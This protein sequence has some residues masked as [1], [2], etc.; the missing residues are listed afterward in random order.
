MI[1]SRQ[2]WIWGIQNI[3]DRENSKCKDSEARMNLTH[4]GPE[5][6]P[7][8]LQGL[9]V[10]GGADGPR[11]AILNSVGQKWVA[12]FWASSLELGRAKFYAH[13]PQE[14]IISCPCR[15]LG[16]PCRGFF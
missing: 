16:P 12:A 10:K 4:Q 15:Q 11:L 14:V 8:W 5:R 6:K 3:P 1:R 13:K 9:E 2:A 7:Q